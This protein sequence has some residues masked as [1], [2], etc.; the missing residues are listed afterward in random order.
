MVTAASKAHQKSMENFDRQGR[1]IYIFEKSDFVN[2][3]ETT[4]R[5]SEKAIKSPENCKQ[6]K[7]RSYGG[8]VRGGKSTVECRHN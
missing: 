5:T 1:R 7:M 8:I 4:L 6:K 2:L 3:D